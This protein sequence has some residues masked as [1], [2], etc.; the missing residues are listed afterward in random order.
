MLK[1]VISESQKRLIVESVSENMKSIQDESVELTKK[2]VSDTYKQTGI[3]LSM[4]LTWGAS[5]GGFIS[6]VSQW[7]QG[8]NPELSDGDIS[9]IL[10][11]VVSVIFYENK[12][13]IKN[14]VKHLKDRNLLN[15]FKLT[16]KKAKDLESTFLA[17]I[18]S[19]NIVSFNMLSMLSYAFLVPL[20]PLIYD[21]V[22]QK[23]FTM[24]DVEMIARSIAGYGLITTG[25]NFLK[26]VIEKLLKRFSS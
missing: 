4:L 25:G 5:I 19:L 7:L 3:N 8:K 21:M 26:H 16:L 6:P 17:F 20:L 22:S 12:E 2:I 9:L 13:V 14:L 23:H 18:K 10:V 24:S 1:V 11:S 15:Y